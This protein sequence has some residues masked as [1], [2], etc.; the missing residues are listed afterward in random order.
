MKK[1][2]FALAA[3]TAAVVATV[4]LAGCGGG[5]DVSGTYTKSY[6]SGEYYA[7]EE[8]QDFVE[9]HPISGQLAQMNLWTVEMFWEAL[10]GGILNEDGTAFLTSGGVDDYYT[11][12]LVLNEDGTY[13]LT[14]EI[15]TDG[16]G[17][18]GAT[19]LGGKTPSVEV[20]FNGEYT[21]DGTTVTL[22]VPQTVTGNVVT[23]GTD[24]MAQY[25][26]LET[27]CPDFEITEEDADDLLYPGRYYYYFNG[28]LFTESDDFT[29][30]TVTVDTETGA[31]DI[32]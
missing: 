10:T 27:N 13:N 25:F 5:V 14:K 9:S 8:V 21:S 17:A 29:E 4:S 12:T 24:S 26:P 23:V 32:A 18:T 22:S 7:I 6:T 16:K 30:M 3:A 15:M 28:L 20:V 19:L 11:V 2:V 31:L 1:K